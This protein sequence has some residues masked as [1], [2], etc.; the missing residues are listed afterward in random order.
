MP[1]THRGQGETPLPLPLPR[2]ARARRENS[3]AQGGCTWVLIPRARSLTVQKWWPEGPLSPHALRPPRSQLVCF[4]LSS[5]V[6]LLSWCRGLVTG[7]SPWGDPAVRGTMRPQAQ[8][9]PFAPCARGC[10]GQFPSNGPVNFG[11][12]DSLNAFFWKNNKNE[13]FLPPAPW[14]LWSLPS[15]LPKIFLLRDFWLLPSIPDIPNS[16]GHILSNPEAGSG[17]FT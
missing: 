9:S 17:L 10:F 4:L 3:S 6:S 16:L 15:W 1:S 2:E 13:C 5:P 8:L 14:W 7:R 12:K 11:E